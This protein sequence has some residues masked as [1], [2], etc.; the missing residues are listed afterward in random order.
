MAGRPPKPTKVK[1]LQ[2]TLQKCRVN[3]D[4]PKPQ[5]KMSPERPPKNLTKGAQE[6]WC[7]ALSQAPEGLLTSLDAA[8]FEQWCSTYDLA[9]RIRDRVNEEGEVIE[10]ENG[11]VM[12]PLLNGYLKLLA[13]LRTLQNDLGF[14]PASRTKI[15]TAIADKPKNDFID[16]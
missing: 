10:T 3:A 2:G 5:G 9:C 14:T 1:E 13:Q 4:E 7:F 12:N 8:V 15:S 11:F 16:L 6:L